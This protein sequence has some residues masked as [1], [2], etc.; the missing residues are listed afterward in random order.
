MV[1][2]VRESLPHMPRKNLGV[3]RLFVAKTEKLTSMT[4]LTKTL[5]RCNHGSWRWPEK[6]CRW[7]CLL[8]KQER[9]Q[10]ENNLPGAFW[11]ANEARVFTIF[12]QRLA[13]QIPHLIPQPHRGKLGN[14]SFPGCLRHQFQKIPIEKIQGHWTKQAE[15]N[16]RWKVQYYSKIIG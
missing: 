5:A 16:G 13:D 12:H 15:R 6:V 11:W 10:P 9:S 3:S 7:M 1:V 8:F 2:I 14:L 4:I